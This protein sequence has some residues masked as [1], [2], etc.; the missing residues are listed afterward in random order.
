[1]QTFNLDITK[2]TIVPLLNAKQRDTGAKIQVMVTDDGKAYNFVEPLNVSIWFSGKSG[3]GNYTFIDDV[4]AVTRTDN[5]LTVRLAPQMLNLP[6]EH[7]MC[8]VIYDSATAAQIGLWNIPYYVEEI[9]GADSAGAQAYYESF[10]DA[11]RRAEEAAERA[12]AAAERAEAS[13]GAGAGYSVLYTPQTLTEEQK[14]QARENIGAVDINTARGELAGFLEES[15]DPIWQDLE[16][17]KTA[18]GKSFEL[19]ETITLNESVAKVSNSLPFACESLFF[20]INIAAADV[21]YTN[22]GIMI[23]MET[24]TDAYHAYIPCSQYLKKSTAVK[25]YGAFINLDGIQIS[26]SSY[27]QTYN[28]TNLQTAFLDRV[29]TATPIEKYRL[30]P[31][32]GS[33]VLPAGSKIEVYGVRA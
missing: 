18:T 15:L 5:V 23:Y 19:I 3:S 7:A 26:L 13:G 29:K 12:E 11:Q 17:L 31:S 6:G 8:I 30:H 28:P 4:P 24:A 27:G 1:M 33:D 25:G 21:T 2:K 10:L 32:S 20:L 16:D 22:A 9:P 14:A